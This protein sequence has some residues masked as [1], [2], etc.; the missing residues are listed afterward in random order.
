MHKLDTEVWYTGDP[1]AEAFST[2][3]V[4]AEV[5]LMETQAVVKTRKH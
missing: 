2:G 4:Q 1:A 5:R 3:R